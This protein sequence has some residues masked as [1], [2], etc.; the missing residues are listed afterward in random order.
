MQKQLAQG[1]T[2]EKGIDV[3]VPRSYLV[4]IVHSNQRGWHG[5][6]KRAWNGRHPGARAHFN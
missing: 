2:L 1:E 5:K 6:S 4:L 3:I